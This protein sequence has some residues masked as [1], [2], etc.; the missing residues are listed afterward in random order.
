[1]FTKR[2]I[3]KDNNDN[4]SGIEQS[5]YNVQ[6]NKLPKTRRIHK[7]FKGAGSGYGSN[8]KYSRLCM[9]AFLLRFTTMSADKLQLTVS[10]NKLVSISL[11]L[12]HLRKAVIIDALSNELS[13][14]ERK[15]LYLVYTDSKS[16]LSEQ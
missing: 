13:S 6:H 2:W 11:F 8:N 14:L 15:L 4:H 3:P 10:A 5:M 7:S 1:M 16:S 12:L 9:A